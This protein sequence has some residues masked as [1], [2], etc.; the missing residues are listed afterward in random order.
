[1]TEEVSPVVAAGAEEGEQANLGEPSPLTGKVA[2]ALGADAEEGEQ[3][4]LEEP[5]HLT[6]E[7]SLVLGSDAE[8]G[9]H[10]SGPSGGEEHLPPESRGG[11]GYAGSSTEV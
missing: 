6:G 4:N 9:G 3:A 7:V 8:E 1:M 11:P 10:S 5:S 2:D